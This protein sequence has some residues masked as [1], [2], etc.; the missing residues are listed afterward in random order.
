MNQPHPDRFN[1]VKKGDDWSL[2]KATEAEFVDRQREDIKREIKKH[3]LA[4]EYLEMQLEQTS[5]IHLA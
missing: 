2:E 1:L 3:I 4:I 5:T